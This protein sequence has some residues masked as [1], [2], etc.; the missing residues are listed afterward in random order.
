VSSAVSSGVLRANLLSMS[1]KSLPATG[2]EI[3]GI[4]WFYSGPT[5]FQIHM[6]PMPT[7]PLVFLTQVFKKEYGSVQA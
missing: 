3:G 6:Q 2:K 1:E 4:I 7:P 5:G